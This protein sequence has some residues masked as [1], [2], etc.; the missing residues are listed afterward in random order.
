MNRPPRNL[1]VTCGGKWA[2]I[3]LQL[4]EAMARIDAFRGGR[5]V[6][7]SSDDL[8]PAGC[9]ADSTHIVPP[10]RDPAYVDRLLEICRTE[11]VRAV[12]PLID[13]DLERLAPHLARFAALGTTVLC[14]P[15]ELVDLGMDKLRFARFADT[16]QLAHPPTW[17]RAEI[18]AGAFPVFAKRRRGFGSIG[19]R[20]CRSADEALAAEVD[21]S[22]LIFQPHIAA[23][24][25]T[26]DC[27]I[28]R[29][30]QCIVCVPRMRDKV[31]AGE[32]YKTHTIRD[33]VVSD[34]A[35]RTV[36]ALAA[37]GLRG[38]L[39]VQLFA[40]TPPLLLEVNTRLGSAVVLSNAAVR[41]RLLDALLLEAAGGTAEGDPADYAA[42]L[43]LSR[44]L[45]DVIHE[46]ARVV[47]VTP[48][49]TTR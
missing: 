32:S 34:L 17:L 47:S 16:H 43:S 5:I 12:V 24:E 31:V 30:G 14:P 9:F 10:I 39:N 40:T 23:P 28:A 46:G 27:Y 36:A 3:V 33:S 26:V 48:G 19:G 22:E 37:A 4:R 42:D 1:L 11:T 2:G 45:G 38:A 29:S 21:G 49:P 8:T 13:L 20:I 18:P 44:F 7:A 15:P 25:V 41:G 35:G 6:V